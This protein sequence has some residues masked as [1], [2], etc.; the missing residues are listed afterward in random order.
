[1]EI[2]ELRSLVMLNDTGSIT[3]VGAALHLT[4]AAI[5]K[6]LKSLERDLETPLYERSGRR[7]RLTQGAEVILPHL[8]EVLAQY[9]AAVTALGEWKGMKTGLV[10]VGAGPSISS[11][12][13][14]AVIKAYRDRYP[15]VDLLVE[16]GA[17]KHLIDRLEGGE[18]DLAM[19]VASDGEED[20]RLHVEAGWKHEVVLVSN[21]PGIPG[22]CSIRELH[23]HPFILFQ[24]GG[25]IEGV[26]ERYF[27]SVGFRPRVSMRLDNAEAIGAM[28]RIGLG[29]SMLP[30]WTVADDLKSGVLMR[31]RQKEKKLCARVELVRAKGR[32]LAHP[33]MAFSEMARN[34]K[35]VSLP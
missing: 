26:I 6:Q 27:A 10:R 13:L 7:L 24:R 35:A 3:A 30:L 12:L 1:M 29:V 22:R 16:T 31:I 25:R 18:L 19:L 20:P 33:V 11:H 28:V 4:P 17:S 21:L 9:D 8:K 14:P 34:P 32:Y 2:R 15:D 23:N 5:H